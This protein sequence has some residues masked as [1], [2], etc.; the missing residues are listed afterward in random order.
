M[1]ALERR[2]APILHSSGP[3]AF[4]QFQLGYTTNDMVQACAVFA[5]RYGISKFC[6]LEGE[7]P[8]GGRVRLQFA[9]CG[10]VMYELIEAEAPNAF[11]RDRLPADR[12]AIRHHH[13]G[14][15]VRSA[16]EWE[17]LE[18]QIS[19]GNW[20]VAVRYSEPGFMQAVYIDAPELGH[21]LEYIFPEAAGMEFF[22]NVPDN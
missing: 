13:I 22:G 2:P 9:W 15:L 21:F 7:M 18:N 11:Y 16:D 14:Y 17:N 8:E 10:G 19:Q 4:E 12:F 5:Q 1:K 20:D 6:A 3:L